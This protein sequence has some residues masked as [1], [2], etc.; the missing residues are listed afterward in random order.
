MPEKPEVM[1]VAK[2]LEKE[3][4]GKTII[5]AKVYWDN[6]IEYP[7]KDKFLKEIKNQKILDINTRG[8]WIVLTLNDYYL[9]FH[10]RMEGKFFF[11]TDKDPKNKHEHV[12]FY[13]SDGRQLRFADVRKFGKVHLIEK[14]K[15]NEVG[16]LKDL[17]VEYYDESFTKE[18]LYSKLQRKS[19][20]IKTVLL[21]QSIIAGIGNIYDN[22]ILFLSGINPYT[23]AKDLSI[24]DVSNIV[25]N[26]KIVL[27]KAV[28]LGGSTIRSYT[29]SEGVH[30]LFQ[31][32]LMVHMQKTCKKCGK[33]ITK[34]YIGGRGTYYCKKCQKMKKVK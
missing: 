31:E 20:P 23:K 32:E 7:S 30:G 22:E 17:G 14:D 33:D 26:T 12:F 13:L 29:S 2:T 11:R 9:L 5:K 18:Y 16:P 4:I 8:K 15:I 6:M 21:D 27:D 24:N 1:T 10:L 3:L 19:L 34:E 28:K 25:S